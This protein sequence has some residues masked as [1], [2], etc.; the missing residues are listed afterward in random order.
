MKKK[1]IIFLLIIF[2]STFSLAK[3]WD[4]TK[5]KMFQ[6]K[7]A[8]WHKQPYIAQHEKITIEEIENI[9]FGN[10]KKYPIINLPKKSWIQS[11]GYWGLGGFLYQDVDYHFSEKRK[12]EKEKMKEESYKKR[13][14]TRGL[15]KCLYKRS[16]SSSMKDYEKCSAQFIRMSMTRSEKSKIRKPGDIFYSLR[17]ILY[18]AQLNPNGK[19]GAELNIF[20]YNPDNKP[21]SEVFCSISTPE[22]IDWKIKMK[23]KNPANP[24]CV[25]FD[26]STLKKLERFKKDPSNEKVLGK[27]LIKYIKRQRMI[28]SIHARMGSQEYYW[29][30]LGDFLNTTV[31][32]VKRN[33]INPDLQKRRTLLKKY[34][35]KLRGIEKKLYIKKYKSI[36][37]DISSISKIYKDLESLITDN[38]MVLNIDEA[39]N[40]ISDSH[41]LVQL[42]TLKVKDNEE[43]KFTALASIYFMQSLID[44]I[45]STI[46]KKY[47]AETKKI[48]KT[49]FTDDELDTLEIIIDSMINK[50][51]EIKSKKLT[52]SMDIINKYINT[53]VI[54]KKLHNLGMKNNIYRT[55]TQETAA[56]VVSQEIRDNLNKDIFKGFE[57]ILR[58]ID[59]DELSN[60][61]KEISD[62][63][64]EA[65]SVA[66]EVSKTPTY[67]SV[68]DHKFGGQSLK[69]LIAAS[70]R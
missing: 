51:K 42:S 40:I 11:Y 15:A 54:L 4:P 69:T 14:Q 1:F 57:N 65:S 21:L 53:S 30:L 7:K 2:S 58:E 20:S 10:L 36:D 46:P 35:L 39:I 18:F 26:K 3:D 32:D 38:E 24:D 12:Y 27:A 33:D 17:A 8:N 45:L 50:N 47:Y 62:V 61:T 31:A 29:D 70:R 67:N 28:R 13:L 43:E 5:Y 23:H 6:P 64:K 25:G 60:L 37:K 59:N 9:F 56:E 68:L 63:A 41:K 49:L 48:N 66:K 44:S 52:E 34:S 22:H 55:F 19:I 16:N